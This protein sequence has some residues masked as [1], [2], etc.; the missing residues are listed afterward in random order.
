[1]KR[2]VALF[3]WLA[4]ALAAPL[5]ELYDR[6]ESALGQVRIEAQ[7]QA[8]PALEQAQ[9]LLRQEGEVLP[10]V[11]RDAA[12]LNLQEARQ[13]LLRKSRADLEARLLLV[14][15]LLGKALLDGFL[16]GTGEERA[17][18][19]GRLARATGLPQPLVQEARSLPPEGARRLLEA[20]Y[21]QAMAEDLGR[22]LSAASRPEAYLALA[23]AY[24]RYLVIQDSPQSTLKAQDF[25]QAL[26]KVS[27]GEPFRAEVAALREKTLAWRKG[28]QPSPKP[29]AQAPTPTP[30]SPLSSP[31]QAPPPAPP[32]TPISPPP[33]PVQTAPAVE[34]FYVASWASPELASQ[35]RSVAYALGYNYVFEFLADL[36]RIA[37]TVGLASSALGRGDTES[38]RAHL[39]SGLFIFQKN[40]EPILSLVNPDLS[41]MVRKGF[42]TLYQAPGARVIDTF[43]LYDAIQELA[44]QFQEGPRSTPWLNFQLFLLNLAGIPRATFFLVAAALAFFPLYLVRLTFGGRNVYWNLLA[45]AF[46]LLFLPILA[47]GLSYFGA[48]MA[49]YGNLPWLAALNNLS[50]G[51]G[52]LPY[53]SWGLSVF[54]VVVLATAGLRG[55]AAQF[56]LLKERGAEVAPTAERLPSTTLTSETIVEWDEE[57]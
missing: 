28:L 21:L 5:P 10:P 43:V 1:M 33:S 38:A 17:A 49:D 15:H 6:L 30:S 56:G 34:T 35:I 37:Q 18:L 24:A 12:L 39:A 14:R 19:L 32:S 36:D 42:T 2:G 4:L 27:G 9:S 55:I 26:A 16:S 29:Q 48:I 57:F 31:T 53:L 13:A 25:V 50:I 8:L 45:L 22:S 3:L 41:E 20:H 23:R 54:L 40:A 46:L 44:R 47:E 51:Q 52:L 11:L 7:N